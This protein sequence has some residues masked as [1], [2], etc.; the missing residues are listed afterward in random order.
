MKTSIK[1]N[2]PLNSVVATEAK[3]KQAATQL[4]LTWY[5]VK[6]DENLPAGC[7]FT[8]NLVY[9]NTIIDPSLTSTIYGPYG[10]ICIKGGT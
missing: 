5:E 8:S 3:C 9:F 4:G 6:T 10:A 2:C 7:Y 1:D